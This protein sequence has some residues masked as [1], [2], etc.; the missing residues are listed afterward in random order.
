V[1]QF[2]FQ[3]ALEKYFREDLACDSFRVTLTSQNGRAGYGRLPPSRPE[4]LKKLPFCYSP[5]TLELVGC[6]NLTTTAALLP[7]MAAE[8]YGR[9]TR[10]SV[11]DA[12]RLAVVRLAGF[13]SL[14]RLSLRG[15]RVVSL[16]G[17]SVLGSLRD[18][19]LASDPALRRL[20]AGALAR[21]AP[22]LRTLSVTNCTALES[23]RLDGEAATGKT[24]RADDPPPSRH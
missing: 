4:P 18:V 17:D 23:V 10:V 9:L 7:E 21:L 1:F 24:D 3:Q 11:V 14:R 19:A 15:A 12:P 13:A 6:R 2:L 22:N 20:D 16:E 5:E 8:F